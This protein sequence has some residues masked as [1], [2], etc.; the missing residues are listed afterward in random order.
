[1]G[2]KKKKNWHGYAPVASEKQFCEMLPK[3]K[4]AMFWINEENNTK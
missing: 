2:W 3:I 4:V 1:M